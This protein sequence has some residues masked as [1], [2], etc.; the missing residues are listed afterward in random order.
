MVNAKIGGGWLASVEALPDERILLKYAS[1]HTQSRRRAV[2]GRLFVTSDRIVF[3]P[4][5]LDAL[6]GGRQWAAMVEQ[7]V[8]VSVEP[9]GGDTF[10]GGL[11]DRLRV[12]T[13]TGCALFVVNKVAQ[14]R[15]EM[16]AAL[17]VS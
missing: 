13:D 2:G 8:R 1:N 7:V 10:G 11:R 6:T 17:D 9:K 12:D 14:V 4:H 16:A 15:S 5:R 3:L